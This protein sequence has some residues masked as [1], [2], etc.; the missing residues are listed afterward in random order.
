MSLASAVSPSRSHSV[1][2]PALLKSRFSHVGLDGQ[3]KMPTLHLLGVPHTIPHEDFAVCAYTNKVVLFP[4]VLRP[5]GWT[6]VEYANEGSASNADEHIVVLTKEQ[7]AGLS[8]RKRRED[9]HDEDAVNNKEL[10]DAFQRALLPKL[11]ARARPGDIVGHM[12]APNVAVHDLLRGCHHVELCV[13][14]SASP[15]LP[16]RI[17]ETSAWMHYHLAKASQKDGSH[18]WVNPGG[19]HY[20]WVIPSP[21]DEG[22]WQFCADPDDYA[23]FFGRITPRK[24]M[25]ELLEIAR[26]MPELIIRV[27]GPGDPSPWAG[28]SP[29]NL[30]FEGPVF[31]AER[32]ELVR[33]A[34]VQLAPTQYIEP[35]GNSGIEGQLCGVPLI[36][37]SFGAFMETIVENVNGYRCHTLADWT[38]AITLSAALD[39]RRIADLARA[40]YAKEV[41]GKQYDYALRQLS[42]LSGRG[43]YSARSRKFPTPAAQ[44]RIW[45]YIPYFGALPN[46]FQLYL[47]SLGRNADCLS[48]ITF[49]D[50]NLDGYSLPKNLIP[51]ATTLPEFRKKLA[52]FLRAELDVEIDPE[53]L[54]Q[55]PH[56]LRDFKILYPAVFEEIGRQHGVASDDFVGWGD[57]DVI[58]GQLSDFL[59]L[60]E[61]YDVIGGLFGHFTA[62]ANVPELKTL[63]RKIPDLLP[64]LRDETHFVVDE[65]AFR[66]PLFEGK[67]R[68]F[69]TDE[70]FCDIIPQ[71]FFHLFP[72]RKGEFFDSTQPQK[73]LHCVRVAHDGR[74][75]VMYTDKISRPAIYC[76]MQKRGMAVNFEPTG[77]DFEVTE[78]GYF[79]GEHAFTRAP[80]EMKMP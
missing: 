57:C 34:R 76:H 23:L 10:H 19:S 41:I 48:V 75:T 80:P 45:L 73:D 13:G 21:V 6:V 51:I 50:A 72:Q 67:F 62:L 14:Y 46:Y 69:R 28:R 61:N 66:K 31:D 36:G 5:L 7:F 22:K 70:H 56:K 12:Y 26:R 40:R 71:C 3:H 38:R 44:R 17:F 11:R 18:S 49:T 42:D 47:D 30:K 55:Q 60:N 16:F 59:D 4:D 8:K 53:E 65:I 25:E 58:Y 77:S 68:L 64:M 54:A 29:P 35:F 79:I 78:R 1:L 2:S 63:Y 33:R 52:E 27:V 43:W 37:N 39:R 32:V 74:L 20:Q 24:G 9:P 15:G